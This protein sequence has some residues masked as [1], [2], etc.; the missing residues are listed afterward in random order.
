M[1]KEEAASPT[2]VTESVILTAV[3]DTYKKRDLATMDIPGAFLHALNDDYVLLL[4]QGTLEELM[5]KIVPHIYS[6]YV[7]VGKSGRKLLYVKLHKALYGMLK[8]ALLFYKKLM[9]DLKSVGFTINPYGPCVANKMVGGK[10]ITVVCHLDDLKVSH[11][12]SR[13]V[14][15]MV[16]WLRSIYGK[17]NVTRGPKH[18][19][20]GIDVDYST[21]GVV[22]LLMVPYMEKILNEFPEELGKSTAT[23]AGDHLFQVQEDSKAKKLPEEQENI[24]HHTLVQLLFLTTRLRRDIQTGS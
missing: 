11:A 21:T 6:K 22:K 13:V 9:K 2:A 8:S 3:I 19:Y 23:P 12:D 20:L 1:T 18:E 16:D 4:F 24:F 7:M 10:Q 17:M 5:V 15:Q 14:D